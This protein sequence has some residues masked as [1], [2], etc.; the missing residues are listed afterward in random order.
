MR[1]KNLEGKPIRENPKRIVSASGGL[2]PLQ[3][4]SESNTGRFFSKEVE[5]RRGGGH[6]AV[7]QRG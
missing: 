4:V 1:F 7:C 3:I 6:Q 5:P 2:G